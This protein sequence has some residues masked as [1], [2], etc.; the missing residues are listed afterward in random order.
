MDP[1]RHIV[2]QVAS[3]A[4]GPLA[5]GPYSEW[6]LWFIKPVIYATASNTLRVET[7]PNLRSGQYKLTV[8]ATASNTL[9]V[10]NRVDRSGIFGV[11]YMG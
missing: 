4:K 8:R 2:T 7:N 6:I 5:S 10:E 1:L 3:N 9:R 11:H